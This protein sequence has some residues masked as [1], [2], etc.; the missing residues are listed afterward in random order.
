MDPYYGGNGIHDGAYQG[1][2]QTT[3][4]TPAQTQ[5]SRE[6]KSTPEEIISTEPKQ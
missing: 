1:N 6:A 3:G 5:A 2:L 4:I